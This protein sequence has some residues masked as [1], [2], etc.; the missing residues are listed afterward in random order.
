M[1]YADFYCNEVHLG[2]LYENGKFDYIIDSNLINNNQLD[3]IAHTLSI[4]KEV[5]L[6]DD[7]NFDSYISSWNNFIFKDNFYFKL[8]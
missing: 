7:F 4:I 8:P 1:K 5:G 6:S 3:I 2:T